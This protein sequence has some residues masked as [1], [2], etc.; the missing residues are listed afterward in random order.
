M[1]KKIGIIVSVVLAL[2][3]TGTII[4][5]AQK[6]LRAETKTVEVYK[7][8][9]YIAM[10][11]E[12]KKDDV[13]TVEVPE[14]MI[15]NLVQD[16]SYFEGKVTTQNI[17]P[18]QFIFEN[19]VAKG[20]AIR[21]GYVEIFIPTDLSKSALAIAGEMVDLYPIGDSYEGVPLPPVFEGAR[22]LHSL[23]QEGKDIDP[24]RAQDLKGIAASGTNIPVSVGVEI[25]KEKVSQIVM[26]AGNK[27]IYLVKSSK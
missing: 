4:F 16:I 23:D 25:P 17:G 7:A 24:S 9:N 5:T 3:F 26:Y 10:G 11:S 21:P 6:D 1:S 19:S 20:L 8:V 27:N 13:K 12:V 2:I 15:D 18:D 22:V 14:K